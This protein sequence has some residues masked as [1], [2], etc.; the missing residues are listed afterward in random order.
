M[1]KTVGIFISYLL[2]REYKTNYALSNFSS[3]LLGQGSGSAKRIYQHPRPNI[4]ITK[5]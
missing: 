5:Q 2:F 4:K 1:S 3:Q